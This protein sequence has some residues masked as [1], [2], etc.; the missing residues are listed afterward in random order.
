MK[1]FSRSILLMLSFFVFSPSFSQTNDTCRLRISLLT[2]GPAAE[3]YS[4]FGHTA[5][6]VID[7]AHR[8]DLVFNYGTFDDSSPYF[9][10]KFTRGIM[11]YALSAYDFNDFL[12]EYISD[13]R[14]VT[15]QV[16]WLTCDEKKTL[17]DALKKNAQEENRY[18]DYQF[19]KD[20][21]TTR[22]RDIINESTNNSIAF[23]N[24]L[25]AKIPSFRQLIHIYL[26]NE[27]QYW[28]KFGIDLLLGSNLDKKTTNQ[29][30]MFLPDYLMTG[31]DSARL[32][33]HPIVSDRKTILTGSNQNQPSFFTP[34]LLF[35]LLALYFIIMSFSKSK[36]G[37]KILHISD[38]IFFFLIGL[39][40]LLIAFVWLARV[41]AVCRNN[42]NILWAWPTHAVVAFLSKKNQ[43]WKK[44]YFLIAAGIALFLLVGW[45]WLPQQLNIAFAPLIFIVMLRS[46]LISTKR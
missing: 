33:Q 21:C 41:D 13:H 30:S 5:V 10:V 34:L 18:Y 16:L 4:T 38:T 44:S 12:Q 32:P 7:S 46:Y 37:L 17:F 25:P 31:L 43:G 42:L 29:E 36:M 9:Y 27:N 24:I 28:S 6:R 20:N 22:A 26:D 35:S 2:C 14:S 23:K 11:R 40:G 3:L 19:Y 45:A 8:M 15:E 1:F 39:L